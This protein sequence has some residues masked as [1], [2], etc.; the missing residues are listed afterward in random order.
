M[1][2]WRVGAFHT[3]ACENLLFRYT[4]P[5]LLFS[6]SPSLCLPHTD[7]RLRSYLRF[8]VTQLEIVPIDVAECRVVPPLWQQMRTSYAWLGLICYSSSS[9]WISWPSMSSFLPHFR[10]HE[11]PARIF[12]TSKVSVSS[13]VLVEIPA[14]TL[15]LSLLEMDSMKS[16][17]SAFLIESR[18]HQSCIV[19]ASVAN[20][21]A[22]QN[23]THLR[24]HSPPPPLSIIRP[25]RLVDTGMEDCALPPNSNKEALLK[26]NTVV[27]SHATSIFEACVDGLK[28]GEI[29]EVMG[30]WVNGVEG[31]GGR[32]GGD[33]VVDRRQGGREGGGG[34]VLMD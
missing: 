8:L 23:T 10:F 6:S 18:K 26:S 12:C 3:L 25:P 34:F 30:N 17:Q 27:D 33:K 13:S 32:R 21:D 2:W 14:A 15:A 7:L 5:S 16:Q 29:G 28:G 19:Y 9:L 11:D 22:I 31:E 4:S 1:W 24:C 20:K